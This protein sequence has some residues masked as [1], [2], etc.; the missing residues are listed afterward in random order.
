MKNNFRYFLCFLLMVT[1]LA[2]AD[3]YE[4]LFPATFQI[5]ENELQRKG[6]SK[7]VVGYIFNVYVAA[8]YQLPESGP[9]QALADQPRHLEIEYLRDLAKDDFT[10]AAEDMLAKQHSPA[11]IASIRDGINEINKLYQDVRK[12]DRYALSYTPGTGTE[13]IFNGQSKGIIPGTD[14]ARIYFSIWLGA[15]HPYQSFRDKLV[16]AK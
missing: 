13:L 1:H 11:V 15:K 5:G 2:A 9:A 10:G 7:L 8:F 12:G 3:R 6:V 16:G 14:F 4:E